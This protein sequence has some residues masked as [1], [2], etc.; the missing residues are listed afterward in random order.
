[1]SFFL[2]KKLIPKSVRNK[3]ENPSSP[4]SLRISQFLLIIS[5]E[6]LGGAKRG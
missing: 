5:Q 6:V 1:M 2:E 4:Y 3:I